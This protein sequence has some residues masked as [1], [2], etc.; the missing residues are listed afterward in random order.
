M[1]RS[2]GKKYPIEALFQE[3]I[4]QKDI[5]REHVSSD[6]IAIHF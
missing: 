4:F 3:R 2:F 6:A 1:K 5:A